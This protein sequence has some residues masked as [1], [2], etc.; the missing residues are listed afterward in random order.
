MSAGQVQGID[1]IKDID[2]A[3]LKI[4]KEAGISK[5]TPELKRLIGRMD[6]LLVTGNDVIKEKEFLFKGFDPKK[7]SEFKKFAS[8][9]KRISWPLQFKYIPESSRKSPDLRI[10]NWKSTSSS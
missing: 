4:S 10:E 8:T 9:A 3:L 5:G 1:L 7:L 6:E 2:A